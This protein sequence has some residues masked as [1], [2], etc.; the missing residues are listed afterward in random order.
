MF[1]V[2]VIIPVY[3][4]EKYIERSVA[5]AL[6]Q[7]EVAE[8]VLIEDNSP[9]NSLVICKHLADNNPKI[10]LYRH[11]NGKN[12]GAGESRNLGIKHAKSEYIAFLDA[13]DYYLKNR[14]TKAK[15]LFEKDKT[16]DGVY[17]AV[18]NKKE[19]DTNKT[20]ST[21]KNTIITID[22]SI[23]PD[24]LFENMGPI[25][26]KGEF[27]MDGITLKKSVLKKTGG[28]TKLELSQD[29]HLWIR[30]SLKA[31][32]VAGNSPKPVAIYVFHDNNRIH[33]NSKL[34]RLRIPM[35]IS[36]MQWSCANLIKKWQFLCLKNLAL[37]HLKKNRHNYKTIPLLL[38]F[39]LLIKIKLI[40][41]HFN[42]NFTLKKY[43][44]YTR[45]AFNIQ[46]A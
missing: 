24:T 12:K 10:K 17:D 38:Y 37:H 14:F 23:T 1:Q 8:I 9:D 15:E 31:K 25:G 21:I 30:L 4:A 44:S 42:F 7:P 34:E 13:D 43:V 2:S 11:P 6:K 29:T 16:I 39:W 28:F 19:I 22:K 41:I 26:T 32:L 46:Q 40:Q 27:H 18:E 33:N 5:S 35:Y 36:L 20:I 45:S 3:K